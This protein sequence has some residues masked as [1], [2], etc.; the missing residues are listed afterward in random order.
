M[1]SVPMK[2]LRP[3]ANDTEYTV[4][5]KRKIPITFRH[6]VFQLFISRS[7]SHLIDFQVSALEA[8]GDLESN[9]NQQR[10][11][12][13]KLRTAVRLHR[14]KIREW[15]QWSQVFLQALFYIPNIIL[16]NIPKIS[17]YLND[18]YWDHCKKRWCR[19]VRLRETAPAHY[20]ASQ[21]I[22]G[23]FVFDSHN[24]SCQYIDA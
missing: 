3:Y 11:R 20:S 22:R 23:L 15:N 17:F 2:N 13:L 18:N 5:R 8:D 19:L 1:S 12:R 24:P 9:R 14:D 16:D 6:H 7:E 21:W 10:F 4:K